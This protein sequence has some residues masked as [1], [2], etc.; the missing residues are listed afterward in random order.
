MVNGPGSNIR[1][2]TTKWQQTKKKN[3][4][5]KRKIVKADYVASLGNVF[6]FVAIH[7]GFVAHFHVDAI[8]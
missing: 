1:W 7:F 2:Q 8:E 6:R 5:K 3:R 4:K